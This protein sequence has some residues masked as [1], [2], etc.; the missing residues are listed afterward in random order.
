VTEDRKVVAVI[1]ARMGSTRLPGKVMAPVAG[2]PMIDHVIERVSRIP[3]VD[4]IV[5]A[6]TAEPSDDPLV[7][8]LDGL[9]ARVIR[10]STTDVLARYWAAAES[11]R[12]DAIVRVTGDC[13]LLSP[14]VAG[15][16]VAAFLSEPDCDYA[17]NTL[18]RTYPRGLDTEV[19]SLAAL[20]V[21][22]A[23]ARSSADREHVTGFIWRQPNRFRLRGVAADVD[24]HTLRWTVD[25]AEDLAL[26]RRIFDALDSRGQP[27]EY[28]DVLALLER[29]PALATINEHVEQRAYGP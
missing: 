24:H 18:V 11:T 14:G 17:S 5:V 21:A 22:N 4:E 19:F 8:H 10:G 1:Q 12:A 28:A 23:E 26:V 15:R 9:G 13:P 25:T 6:T 20:S 27:F 7:D 16:V 3:S 2:R 29:D